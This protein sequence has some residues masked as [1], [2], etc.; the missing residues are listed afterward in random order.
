MAANETVSI[1]VLINTAESTKSLTEL[2]QVTKQ[3]QDQLKQTGLGAADINK[4][5][6]ALSGTRERVEDIN[7][8]INA[9]K[10]G[11]IQGFASLGRNIAGS[12]GVATGALGLFGSK[13]EELND[14]INKVN[15]SVALL[16]G[17]QAGADALRDAGILKGLVLSKAKVAATELETGAIVKQTIAQRALNLVMSANPIALV[18]TAV[19]ALA[20]GF[21][22]LTSRQDEASTSQ[23]ELTEEE[24]KYNE[25]VKNT[26]ASL[27]QKESSLTNEIALLKTQAG[28]QRD[29]K[30]LEIDKQAEI[31]AERNKNKTIIDEGEALYNRQFELITKGLFNLTEKEKAELALLRGDKKIDA[32]ASFKEVEA[33]IEEKYALKRKTIEDNSFE[34][35]Q[36][37]RQDALKAI[38]N[39]YKTSN[40]LS[41]R[42]TNDTLQIEKKAI[43]QSTEDKIQK[44]RDAF[45]AVVNSQLLSNAELKKAQEAA[46]AERNKFFDNETAALKEFQDRRNKLLEERIQNES[47]TLGKQRDLNIQAERDSAAADIKQNQEEAQVRF[48]LAEKA[49]QDEL[50]RIGKSFEDKN[51]VIKAQSIRL[52][53]VETGLLEDKNRLI[54]EKD[55]EFTLKLE[56]QKLQLQLDSA[57]L[58]GEQTATIELQILDNKFEQEKL[59]VSDN[60]K[61]TDGLTQAR[62]EKV[63]AQYEEQT[64]LLQKSIDEDTKK[65]KN[66]GITRQLIDFEGQEKYLGY[67]KNTFDKGKAL[68]DKQF[69]DGTISREKYDRDLFF[70]Q[71][72][73]EIASLASQ[74]TFT[75]DSKKIMADEQKK[76]DSLLKNSLTNRLEEQ[77]KSQK[78]ELD[79]LISFSED[80]INRIKGDP[81]LNDE[82]KGE[83]IVTAEKE[84]EDAKTAIVKEGVAQRTRI[85]AEEVNAQVQ[86]YA[87][88]GNS[89]INAAQQV[90][91]AII[92]I[93]NNRAAIEAQ[94]REQDYTNLSQKLQDEAALETQALYDKY[95]AEIEAKKLTNEYLNASDQERAELLKQI[96]DEQTRKV[97][98]AQRK[99]VEA[100]FKAD[101]DK[102]VADNKAIK[103]QND[104]AKKA[105]E[106]QKALQIAQV[107]MNT[108][109]AASAAYATLAA[110]TVGL[111]AAPF[112]AAGIGIAGAAQVALIAS[113]KFVPGNTSALPTLTPYDPSS[114]SG[115]G[116][117]SGSSSSQSQFVGGFDFNNSSLF[118]Q[119]YPFPMSDQ[120]VYVLESDIT[121]TQGRVATIEDRNTF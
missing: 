101:Y 72:K 80:K 62:N 25:E 71:Q 63:K 26:N 46:L 7:A 90:S 47:A 83:A 68:L 4:I 86:L 22:F 79:N 11:G 113:T 95:N 21:A 6:T 58:R 24:K 51:A 74:I 65:I 102:A 10:D 87:Q 117:G 12:F 38:E 70:L 54:A 20:A 84:L 44:E 60:D 31:D 88:V 114:S 116:T 99:Q 73:Y 29:L 92:E 66:Q 64:D 97:A 52:T 119:A 43:E 109:V 5:E 118:G 75:D 53:N 100:K 39:F 85:I 18:I 37:R 36:K 27:A 120:R 110:T 61:L 56:E 112:V 16:S 89:L 33:K 69:A 28:K 19:A 105:F 76:I 106:I 103:D 35:Q 34:D 82:Q 2:R 9:G 93:Q 108:V 55:K 50:V 91:N 111:A 94:Q 42:Y 121:T 104:R 17:I 32:Y 1:D 78:Q 23:A 57:K 67:L 96:E 13:N 49:Y 81:K 8:A 107:T 45:N 30:A 115:G 41:Q 98:E 15:A 3:L 40:E 48:N 14:I 77:R 59:K